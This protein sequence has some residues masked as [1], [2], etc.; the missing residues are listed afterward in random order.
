VHGPV[1]SGH[2]WRLVSVTGRVESV[3]KLGERW[4]AELALGTATLVVLGQPG[5]RIPSAALTEG[6][7]AEVV[8]IVRP[9]YPTASDKRPSIL[10]RSTA[11]VH[12]TGAGTAGAGSASRARTTAT[13]AS[14]AALGSGT[15]S[16]VD[17]DLID[18]TTFIGKTVRVG[19]LVVALTDDGFTIDDGTATGRI[20]LTGAAADLGD[21]I[22]PGDAINA[23]GTV[24]ESTDDGRVV[25][26]DDPAGVV[27]GSALGSV[28]EGA[29]A[30]PTPS[31]VPETP[32]D[33]RIAAFTDSI[34]SL[35]GAGAGIAGLLAVG[36]ASLAMAMLRRRH[37]RRVLATRLALISRASV[38]PRGDDPARKGRSSAD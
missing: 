6:R 11:D 7:I 10:P 5:A 3:R 13:T 24:A 34:G 37:G 15:V 33:A 17:A 25:V 14:T 30:S 8:G 29:S 18:L 20:V 1:T 26:V 38:G 9:A 19:G 32:T 35:P 12:Q 4:R 31:D 22:E 2:A 27:L 21:L 28:D 36:A 16:V 23:T